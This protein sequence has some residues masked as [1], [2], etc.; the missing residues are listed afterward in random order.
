[1]PAI[2]K[3]VFHA[4]YNRGTRRSSGPSH[5][6]Q[7]IHDD[8]ADTE[9]SAGDERDHKFVDDDDH[10]EHYDDDDVARDV[11]HHRNR[12]SRDHRTHRDGCKSPDRFND[13]RPM[14]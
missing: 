12:R 3:G 2:W 5:H 6:R 10:N 11:D 1:L 8:N 14:T 4:G 13:D 9:S 7:F